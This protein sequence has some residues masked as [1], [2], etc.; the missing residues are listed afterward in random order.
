MIRVC[1][2]GATGWAG[3]ALARAVAAANDLDLVAAVSRSHAGETLGKALDEPSLTCPVFGS[4][5]EALEVPC[6]VFVE[7]TKPDVAMANISHA[8]GKGVCVVVGTSGL[9]DENYSQLDKQAKQQGL[10]VLAVGNF[11]IAPALLLKFAEVAAKYLPNWEIFDYS[12]AS[13]V[14][15]PSGTARE[16][17][18]RLSSQSQT[19]AVP[20]SQVQGTVEA[21]GASIVGTQVHSVRLLG[22][23]APST[24]IIFGLPDQRLT[25]RHDA[26]SGAEPYVAGALMAVRGV[27]TLTGVHRGLDAVMKL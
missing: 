3:S 17:A 20:L 21:R 6:D 7:Y 16:L 13:K 19:P 25:I 22:Y 4:A 27:Q 23:T 2:A 5:A 9:T 14:D 10:G 1:I 12:S 15:A 11:A 8:L 24:E 26:G 18:F